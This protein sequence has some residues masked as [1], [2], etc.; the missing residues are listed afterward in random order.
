MKRIELNCDVGDYVH[1]KI[2]PI[3]SLHRIKS[4]GTLNQDMQDYMRYWT[5]LEI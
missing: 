4:Q 2:N 3:K 5:K 1:L